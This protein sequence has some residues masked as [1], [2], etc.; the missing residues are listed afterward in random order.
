MLL[1]SLKFPKNFNIIIAES[2]IK[3]WGMSAR[4]EKITAHMDMVPIFFEPFGE[5]E[6]LKLRQTATTKPKT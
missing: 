2:Y 3:T 1:L 5:C 6:Q 4:S